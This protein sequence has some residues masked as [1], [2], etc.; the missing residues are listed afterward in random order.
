MPSHYLKYTGSFKKVALS[1]RDDNKSGLSMTKPP[2]QRLRKMYD[3]IESNKHSTLLLIYTH[4][5][6]NITNTHNS[7][8]ILR[9]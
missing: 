5:V 3:D 2:H 6:I 7:L 8:P 1:D 4:R 9:R